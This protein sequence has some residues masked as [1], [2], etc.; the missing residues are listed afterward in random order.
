MCYC[1]FS[2]ST[3]FL[4]ADLLAETLFL[5]RGLS[6]MELQDL[7]QF[8]SADMQGLSHLRIR[9][10]RVD[11][12]RLRLAFEIVTTTHLRGSFP[13]SLFLMRERDKDQRCPLPC[14][15]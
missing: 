3:L 10:F 15:L 2:F 14:S 9:I 7:A 6:Q 5:L 13:P 8:L 11:D 4:R 12:L 1:H